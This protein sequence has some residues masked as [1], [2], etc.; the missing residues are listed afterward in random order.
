MQKQVKYFCEFWLQMLEM[1]LR[2]SIN[3]CFTDA[4]VVYMLGHLKCAM[5]ADDYMFEP[6]IFQHMYDR[7]SLA[8]PRFTE[9]WEAIEECK[10]EDELTEVQ[11]EYED[12]ATIAMLVMDVRS[13]TSDWRRECPITKAN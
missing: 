12:S 9:A 8:L 2:Q 4:E 11:K 6:M 7:F 13:R 5:V 1:A 3:I 10:N